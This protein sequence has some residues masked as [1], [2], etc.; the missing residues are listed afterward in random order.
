[1]HEDERSGAAAVGSGLPMVL[2]RTCPGEAVGG[3]VMCA[4][5]SETC[6]GEGA[7]CTR[8]QGHGTCVEAVLEREP[9]P[10]GIRGRIAL[11]Q[12][13]TGQRAPL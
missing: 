13:R 11:M 1:M 12:K 5:F 10:I 3:G 9:K 7:V 4:S 2:I 8:N 6:V